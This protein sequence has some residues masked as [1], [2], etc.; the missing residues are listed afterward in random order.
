V[1]KK[2]HLFLCLCLSTLLVACATPASLPSVQSTPTFSPSEESRANTSS[3][4]LPTS[5]VSVHWVPDI[6]AAAQDLGIDPSALSAALG[7]L[8]PSEA[9]I[10]NAASALH[11]DVETLRAALNAHLHKVTT[12]SPSS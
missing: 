11:L 4:P 3:A 10:Q 9:Q 1:H 7:S 6:L 8:P 5:T 12:S 2:I